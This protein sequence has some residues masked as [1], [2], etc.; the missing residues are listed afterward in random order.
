MKLKLSELQKT[1]FHEAG[2]A[3]LYHIFGHQLD[4]VRANENG[5]G[6]TKPRFSYLPTAFATTNTSCLVDKI[7][8]YGIICFGGYFA[9]FKAQK[10]NLDLFTIC[11]I[12]RKTQNEYLDNDFGAIRAQMEIANDILGENLF[13]SEFFHLIGRRTQAILKKENVWKAI[14]SL[15]NAIMEAENNNLNEKEINSLLSQFNLTDRYGINISGVFNI[16]A[17]CS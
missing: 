9:E 14:Q 7:L 15:S 12:Y 17:K 5:E 6:Y 8:Q 3:V 13:D 16:K 1:A 2:H 4:Y 11:D 10:R